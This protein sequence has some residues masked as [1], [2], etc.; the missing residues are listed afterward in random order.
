MTT[1]R[2][3]P[4]SQRTVGLVLLARERLL[5]CP[6]EKEESSASYYLQKKKKKKKKKKVFKNFIKLKI[7]LKPKW[8]G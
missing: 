4:F 7:F 3:P 8:G 2:L 5:L 6:G 1:T